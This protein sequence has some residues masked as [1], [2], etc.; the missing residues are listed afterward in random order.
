ML[1]KVLTVAIENCFS[2]SLDIPGA[3]NG[4]WWQ[5][6]QS[7]VRNW[8]KICEKTILSFKYKQYNCK[9]IIS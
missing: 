6:W 9:M 3:L 2:Y 5:N 1:V 4:M 7:S 8:N